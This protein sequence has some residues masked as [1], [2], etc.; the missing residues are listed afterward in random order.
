MTH[1][2]G[3][4]PPNRLCAPNVCPHRTQTCG[5]LFAAVSGHKSTRKRAHVFLPDDLLAEVDALVGPRGR[6]A[7]LTEVI[8]EAV[9]RT[10]LL[11]FLSSKEPI[12]KEED[13]PELAEGADTWVRRLRDESLRLEREKL[14]D[15]WVGH[16]DA[17]E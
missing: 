5:K 3:Y 11:H 7:F 10:R 14:G 1:K 15:R 8:R 17:R 2:R 13:H 12:W 9:N 6:S 16:G 4:G